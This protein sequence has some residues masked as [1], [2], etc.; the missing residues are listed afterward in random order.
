MS[1]KAPRIV[2]LTLMSVACFMSVT[3]AAWAIIFRAYYTAFIASFGVLVFIPLFVE[4]RGVWRGR[5]AMFLIGIVVASVTFR[6]PIIEI[7]ARIKHLAEKPRV[8]GTQATFSLRDKLGIYGLNMIMGLFAYP[9]Y[10]EASRETLM[11]TSN[12]SKDGV[13]IFISDFAINSK[14]VRNELK[15]FCT[16]LSETNGA[17][18]FILRKR[19]S[20]DARDYALGNKEARYAL[21]LNPS[22]LLLVAR[23][24]DSGWNIEVSLLVEIRYPMRSYVMVVSQPPLWIEEGL[25]W[26]LQEVGWLF[27]YKAEWKFTV[28]SN[29]ERIG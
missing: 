11:M 21:A 18:K 3:I 20:W 14:I 27:P 17:Q 25:F 2:L 10:P 24:R 9:I 1:I 6:W 23:Q 19:I 12:S 8:H 13:R 15:S 7:N 16:Q 5:G 26:A 29:D 28:D 4:R 22:E